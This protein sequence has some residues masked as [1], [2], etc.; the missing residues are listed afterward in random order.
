MVAMPA[1][2][3]PKL[4]PNMSI[5]SK[6]IFSIPP[7]VKPIIAKVALPSYLRILLQTQDITIAGA[8]RKIYFPYFIASINIVS[9]EPNRIIK[10]FKKIRPKII[11]HK[12][13]QKDKN[14]PLEA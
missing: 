3:I 1:P 5:G 2:D 8:A 14:K 11:R 6:I 10:G 13:I 4:N 12:E 9:V 7:V